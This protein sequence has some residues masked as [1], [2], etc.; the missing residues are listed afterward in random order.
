M[1]I[2]LIIAYK[3]IDST[4]KLFKHKGSK[5]TKAQV[6]KVLKWAIEERGYTTTAQLT[7]NAVDTFLGLS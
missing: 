3:K 5:L 6:R 7:D 2:E 4:Y 1:Q